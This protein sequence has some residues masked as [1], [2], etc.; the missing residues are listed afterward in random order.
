MERNLKNKL[1][2]QLP[3]LVDIIPSLLFRSSF[4]LIALLP[5]IA[6]YS[7]FI[8]TFKIHMLFARCKLNIWN[9]TRRPAVPNKSSKCLLAIRVFH[10]RPVITTAKIDPLV[11]SRNCSLGKHAPIR[12]GNAFSKWMSRQ[13]M[14]PFPLIALIQLSLAWLLVIKAPLRNNR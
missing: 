4:I 2:F 9:R 11:C 1:L 12:T 13:T 3:V 5:E 7:T 6:L 14:M 10:N 8:R